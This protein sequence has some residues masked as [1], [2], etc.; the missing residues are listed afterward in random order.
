MKK[1]IEFILA[2]CFEILTKYRNLSKPDNS[3]LEMV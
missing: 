1:E 2:Y 3:S